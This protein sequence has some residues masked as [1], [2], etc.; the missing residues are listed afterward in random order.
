MD[1]LEERKISLLFEMESKKLRQEMQALRDSFAQMQ[2]EIGV[3]KNQVVRLN[4]TP[5]SSAAPI[6]SS[7]PEQPKQQIVVEASGA[8]QI[9]TEMTY[10]ERQA[11]QNKVQPTRP[12]YGEYKPQDV[13]IDKI[14]YFGGK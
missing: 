7:I 11:M 10:Q 6:A 1:A 5:A 14:F 13:A 4:M 12:R 9:P 3:L 8:T 2:G